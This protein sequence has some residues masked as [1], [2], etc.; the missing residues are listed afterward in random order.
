[1][2]TVKVSKSE[3]LA[4]YF[5][6]SNQTDYNTKTT[7]PGGYCWGLEVWTIPTSEN[8]SEFLFD[9]EGSNGQLDGEKPAD[10]YGDLAAIHR[11]AVSLLK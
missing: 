3:I 8:Y 7:C 11:K 9:L 2:T 4:D 1:M 5:R 6:K 10:L